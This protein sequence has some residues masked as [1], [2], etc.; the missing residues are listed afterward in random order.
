MKYP[1]SNRSLVE[2]N[3]STSEVCLLPELQ[4][5]KMRIE[6]D[7]VSR[8]IPEFYLLRLYSNDGSGGSF[9]DLLSQKM[10]THKFWGEISRT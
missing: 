9:L 10:L 8:M 7:V 2:K 6:P 5:V 3:V 4:K 1:T